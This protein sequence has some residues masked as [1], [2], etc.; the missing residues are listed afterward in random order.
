MSTSV[1][2]AA[3]YCS[4]LLVVGCAT[5]SISRVHS[6]HF[7]PESLRVAQVVAVSTR[8]QI[9]KMKGSQLYEDILA[10]GT[11]DSELVDGSLVAVRIYCCGGT[12]KESSAEY[13]NTLFLIVPKGMTLEGGEFVEYKVGRAR[14]KNDG[15]RLNTVTRVV[16]RQG[17]NPESC[18]WDPR[19]DRLWLRVAYCAWMPGEGWVKQG[20]ITPG[21]YKPAR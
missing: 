14:L 16:A 17:D 2:L 19:D 8:A 12:T 18:W 7:P 20:G 5:S 11:A 21:W 10:A 9:D 13:A 6:D 4:L 15:G 1:R 3:S